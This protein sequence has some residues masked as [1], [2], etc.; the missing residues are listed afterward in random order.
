[1]HACRRE[2][3][4][5]DIRG[6]CGTPVGLSSWLCLIFDAYATEEQAEHLRGGMLVCCLHLQGARC[7]SVTTLRDRTGHVHWTHALHLT[8]HFSPCM[9]GAPVLALHSWHTE[10]VQD[11]TAGRYN[12]HG[13]SG[14]SQARIL[15]QSNGI[16]A[17]SLD[18]HRHTSIRERHSHACA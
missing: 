2:R 18:W 13:T 5:V 14:S 12:Y 1:M 3:C 15:W 11:A 16:A 6:S 4:N 9:C 7:G 17:A 8:V 10:E